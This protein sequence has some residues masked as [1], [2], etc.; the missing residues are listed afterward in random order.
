MAEISIL[1]N[2]TPLLYYYI[3]FQVNKISELTSIVR[4]TKPAK[5]GWSYLFLVWANCI[6]CNE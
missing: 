3:R 1:L 6:L 5:N 2:L 4:P